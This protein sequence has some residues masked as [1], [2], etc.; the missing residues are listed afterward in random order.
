[1]NAV[2]D[3]GARRRLWV[4]RRHRVAVGRCQQT[5]AVCVF[6]ARRATVV[7]TPTLSLTILPQ[8]FPEDSLLDDSIREFY[9]VLIEL[10]YIRFVFVIIAELI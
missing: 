1:M 6:V 9:V 10:P 8:F 3:D 7:G 4:F 5:D 2:A